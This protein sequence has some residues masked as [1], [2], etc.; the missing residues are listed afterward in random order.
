MRKKE[1]KVQS[2][3]VQN[4]VEALLWS[5][6]S[7]MNAYE[8]TVER[9]GAAIK[10]GLYRPGDQLPTE[11]EL[12]E[13]MGVSR[14]TLREAIRVLVAQGFLSVKRGRT[15]GT[16]VAAAL[17]PPS[18][19]ELKQHL[20]QSGA[21]LSDILDYRLI[22]E[23]GVAALAAQRATRPQIK[24]MQTLV[25][26]MPHVVNQFAEHRRLDT[27]FHLAIAQ[28]TQSDRLAAIVASI[29][30]EL[31]DL[32]A[33][34]PHSAAACLDSAMQHQQILAA[35]KAAQPE[36]TRMLMTQHIVRTNSLLN[37]LLG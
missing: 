9:L 18:V 8:M 35:I 32:L 6:K 23:P 13:L 33:V 2:V 11:R 28:A 14:T 5:A 37:V 15:G 25:D 34:I 1:I 36:T 26:R 22:V 27:E 7:S 10:M 4:S 30:A 31:S 24:A 17:T 16:F 21:T 29:H 12:A 3:T 19:R 20:E